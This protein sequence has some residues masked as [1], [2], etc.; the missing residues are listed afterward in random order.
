[1]GDETKMRKLRFLVLLSFACCT[2]GQS[3]S[4]KPASND[5]PAAYDNMSDF[6]NDQNFPHFILA[7]RELYAHLSGLKFIGYGAFTS[8]LYIAGID[9]MPE[10]TVPFTVILLATFSPA[11]SYFYYVIDGNNQAEWILIAINIFTTFVLGV[12]SRV[13]WSIVFP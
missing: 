1:M 9:A 12:D 11:F 2:L 4:L 8:L 7:A 5:L 6:I 3:T 10:A 13:L